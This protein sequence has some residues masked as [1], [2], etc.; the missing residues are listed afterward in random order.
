MSENFIFQESEIDRQYFRFTNEIKERS[1]RL[2]EMDVSAISERLSIFDEF[3]QMK[4]RI[5]CLINLTNLQYFFVSKNISDVLGYP[6][7]TFKKQGLRMAFKI[8]PLSHLTLPLTLVR[9]IKKASK[10]PSSR[11]D[12][13]YMNGLSMKHKSGKKLL[14]FMQVDTIAY[15]PAGY[16]A[17]TLCSFREISHLLKSKEYWVRFMNGEQPLGFVR[18]S[19]KGKFHTDLFTA[20]E[21]E[22]LNLLID[23]SSEEIARRLNI[24]SGT[25]IKHRKNML[26]KTGAKDTTALIQLC[27]MSKVL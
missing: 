5:I 26:L 22:V 27:K 20:R 13:F 18:S 11:I 6:S 25:I 7:E 4:E 14:F 24:T 15:S 17:I 12:K 8:L 1:G 19:D 2:A 16:P 21:K 10:S 9:W 23:H 3:D